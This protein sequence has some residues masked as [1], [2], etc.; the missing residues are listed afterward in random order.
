MQ[1][2][3]QQ[4]QQQQR[5]FTVTRWEMRKAQLISS[6]EWLPPTVADSY[7]DAG[8]LEGRTLWLRDQGPVTVLSVIRRMSTANRILIQPRDDAAEPRTV[9]IA[10]KGK[11]GQ[12]WLVSAAEAPRIDQVALLTAEYKRLRA[13]S[14]RCL[15]L[16]YACDDPVPREPAAAQPWLEERILA[17]RRT[18]RSQANPNTQLLVQGDSGDALIGGLVLAAAVALPVVAVDMVQASIQ[19]T[20]DTYKHRQRQ[21]AEWMSS[22]VVVQAE[23]L[24]PPAGKQQ[25][26][27][28]R[29]EGEEHGQPNKVELAYAADTSPAAHGLSIVA[30]LEAP[31]PV[32][33][34]E[35]VIDTAADAQEPL[36]L[37]LPCQH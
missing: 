2:A 5:G 23:E 12:P 6:G 13:S 25:H 22:Q 27:Q 15:A 18:R 34:Q 36:Q 26:E 9:T 19:E 28:L 14:V 30:G 20:T 10:R 29:E 1:N 37:P 35:S 4:Q 16:W 24:H 32:L 17:M 7:C 33:A 8:L 3:Q 21:E 31:P 11:G